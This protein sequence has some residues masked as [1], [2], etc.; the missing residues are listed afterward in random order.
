[1]R[2]EEIVDEDNV[3]AADRGKDDVGNVLIEVGSGDD[4]V[5]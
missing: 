2:D 5:Q 3:A 1:M 4:P